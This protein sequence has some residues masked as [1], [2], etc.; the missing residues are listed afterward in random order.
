MLKE[1]VALNIE[2]A[3]P[4]ECCAANT[5]QALACL[6]C[7]KSVMYTRHC[8]CNPVPTGSSPGDRMRRTAL[9][10]DRM[11]PCRRSLPRR[12]FFQA[13]DARIVT[14]GPIQSRRRCAT[15]R[16]VG[17]VARVSLGCL[18]SVAVLRDGRAFTWGAGQLG[19]L[20]LGGEMSQPRP[21]VAC[22]ALHPCSRLP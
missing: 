13:H 12:C 1:G 2:H 7:A 11:P 22:R 14:F 4:A 10:T 3:P 20:G 15:S 6:Y 19:R 5:Q 8:R 21:K 9:V 18:H 17:P 16:M